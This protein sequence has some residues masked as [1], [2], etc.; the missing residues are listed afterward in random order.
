MS[1]SSSSAS[2]DAA[3]VP[4]ADLLPEL[5]GL[6]V[7]HLDPI[8]AL[9]FPAVCTG[10]ATTCKE[11]NPLLRSGAPALLTSGLDLEGVVTEH[12]V[13]AGAFGLHDVSAA[14]GSGR[15]SFLGEAEGLKGRTWIGGKDDWLVTTDYNLNV[16]LLNLVTGDRIPLPPFD[17]T[18]HGAKL[19]VQ[20]YFHVTSEVHH[21][22][23]IIK[24]T[25]CQTPAHHGG[26]L[27]IALFSN[28]FLASTAVGDKCW[29]VL[30][31]PAAAS[32]LDLSYMD[33]IVI[34]GKLFAVNES[35]RVYSWDMSSKTTEP[36]MVQ[37]P[38]VETT[39]HYGGFYLATSTRRQFL[40]VYVYGD[41]ELFRDNRVH[42]RL[43][44]NERWSFD[45]LGMSLH[46]LDAGG[47]AAWRRVTDLGDDCA[48]FLGA[49]HP[50]YITVPPGSEDLKA[51]CVYVADTPSGYDAGV[52]DLN[53]GEEDGFVERQTGSRRTDTDSV[54]ESRLSKLPAV[55]GEPLLRRN[56]SYATNTR[57]A[58]SGGR[59]ALRTST[60][61]SA[62]NN[63]NK[64]VVIPW[65]DLLPEVCDLVL[66][67]LDAVS[68]VRFPAA[69]SAWAAASKTPRLRSS[70]PALIT[71]PVDPEGYDIEY[72]VEEGTFGL[73]DV[74]TGKSFQGEAPG[75]KNRTW[76]GGKDD[77]LVTTDMRCGVEL[78][79]LVTG[80]RVPLPSFTTIPGLR[81]QEFSDVRVA[82]NHQDQHLQQVT[83]CQT[84]AHPKGVLAV[85]LFSFD[86]IAF[87]AAGDEGWMPLKNPAVMRYQ[88]YADAIV[89]NGKVLAV[90]T[91]GDICSWDMD[92]TEAEPTMLQGPEEVFIDPDFI[93]VFYL[94]V[95]SNG[96]QLQ[97]VCL[98]G[99]SDNKDTRTM[100][101]VIKDQLC[102]FSASRVSLH[103]LDAAASTWRRVRDLG[104]DRALFVGGNHP[105]YIAVPPGGGS[106]DLQADW[107]YVANL[108]GYDAA[109]F[110]L[111]LAD[112]EWGYYSN[113][114]AIRRLDYPAMGSSQQMPMWFRPT[115][116]PV[117]ANKRT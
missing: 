18:H 62:S 104:G 74:T 75:L 81:V 88:S 28:G 35:G 112:G 37:G 7:D 109:A 63:N 41:N 40:L 31:N 8:S 116:H 33:A 70:T 5:C 114:P 46:E 80:E 50:F 115:A 16:E 39:R 11:N 29:T 51:N 3:A 82:F 48:L 96:E 60:M 83:L 73:H 59:P 95:S 100:R 26:Y 42:S 19:E 49:N 44:F 45:E 30:K 23:K 79:N 66:D 89:F 101:I 84:P 108:D 78:L 25:L 106:K 21:W 77:W 67:R 98:Y 58:S 10:W 68:V 14:T 34:K 43:V 93:R 110:N 76:V 99:Y 90:T 71:S 111:K 6:V 107:V 2:N 57:A 61:S 32:R 36:A 24:V 9:R 113:Y 102:C 91:Y 94:A 117:F 38:E 65:A 22:H 55:Q 54:K 47:S 69:C 17:A 105:F 64:A 92:D 13:D 85:A 56:L 4:W 53:K 27:A 20:G 72:N 15:S 86:L 1:S 87:T 52:F 12:D 103:E 97:V